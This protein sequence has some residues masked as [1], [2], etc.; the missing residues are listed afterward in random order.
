MEILKRFASH[1]IK[2]KPLFSE[3]FCSVQ[4]N[5]NKNFDFSF[6]YFFKPCTFFLILAHYSADCRRSRIRM[7]TIVGS[8]YER[9][10]DLRLTLSRDRCASWWQHR[11]IGHLSLSLTVHWGWRIGHCVH[12]TVIFN[13]GI[14]IWVFHSLH[15]G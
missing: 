4:K 1:F 9:F 10:R 12:S 15:C 6:C 3:E 13:D 2:H 8:R 11:W 14:E 5:N 7:K